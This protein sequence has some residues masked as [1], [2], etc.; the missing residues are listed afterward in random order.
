MAGVIFG[1][2]NSAK[3]HKHLLPKDGSYRKV[4]WRFSHKLIGKGGRCDVNPNESL[5]KFRHQPVV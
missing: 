3:K 1:N 5:R 4:S 2:Q